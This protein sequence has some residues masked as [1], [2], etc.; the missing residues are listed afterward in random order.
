MSKIEPIIAIVGRPNVGKSTL[1]N[2]IAQ[3]RKSI[4]HSEAGITRDRLYELVNWTGR[5]FVLIDTGG[6]VPESTDKIE[7]AIRYQVQM[8]IEEA[9]LVLFMVDVEDLVTT[10]DREIA[11]MLRISGKQILLVVNKSDNEEREQQIFEFFEFGF[12]EPFPISA[13]NGRRIGDLLDAILEKL[14]VDAPAEKESEEDHLE[15]A[16]VGMPNSGKS[17]IVNALIGAEK[18]IVTDIPGTTRDSVD[19]EIKYYGQKVTIIDT[20]GL[21]RKKNISSNVEFYSMVRANLAI[22]RCQVALMVIDATKGFSRQDA[23]IIRAIIDKKKGLI[24]AVNKWDLMDKATNTARDYKQTIIDQYRALEHYPVLFV[25]ALTK[26]RVSKI[27]G[28]VM[29]VYRY[30]Q[31]RISTAK[32]NEYF[33]TVIDRT[34]PPATKGK[35]IK[36]KYV[37]QLKKDPPIFAFY[38]N[39]P[40][41][42]KEEYKRFLE[43]KL[44]EEFRFAG[45]P[46]TIYFRQK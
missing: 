21:R 1:F 26:Q 23:N 15:L 12:G 40:Q 27:L 28:E 37:T 16:I 2:R 8:A 14:P 18:A 7:S 4:I 34:P 36:I 29:E 19:S 32:L 5:Q 44:R 45:V 3:K 39:D 38:C 35:H 17:S 25:S 31:L 41:D 46:L 42:V 6:F 13:I 30:R 22:E 24:V 9:D 20:A 33:Q 11:G 10:M 43:N